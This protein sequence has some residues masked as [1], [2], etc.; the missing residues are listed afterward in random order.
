MR[1][2][3]GRLFADE[4]VF[5]EALQPERLDEYRHRPRRH[6]LRGHEPRD[7]RGLEPPGPPP[8]IEKKAGSLGHRADDRTELG[9]HVAHPGPLPEHPHPREAGKQFE[10]M[11]RRAFEERKGGTHVVGRVRVHLG[12]NHQ[13]APVGLA[14]IYV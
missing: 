4:A 10:G 7:R 12:T 5:V 1:Y 3:S 8:H 9:G 14:H 2:G 13:L 6:A 11:L